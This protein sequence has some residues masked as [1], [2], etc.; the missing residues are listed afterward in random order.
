M[1]LDKETVMQRFYAAFN[2]RTLDALDEVMTADVVDHNPS[3][4]QPAGLAGVKM[5]LASFFASFSDIQ[6][7]APA[8]QHVA[9]AIHA[10]VRALYP[11]QP[12]NDGTYTYAFLMDPW[13]ADAP[14]LFTVLF[15]QVY[16]EEETQAYLRI[17]EEVQAAPQTVHAF[18]QSGW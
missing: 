12:N 6:I 14:Y 5:A 10:R 16:T 9:P 17:W 11:S 18:V 15:P 8:L 2:T 13:I 7:V 3:P 4:E 1:P